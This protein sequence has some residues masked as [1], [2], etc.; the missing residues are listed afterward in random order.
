MN[1]SSLINT[2]QTI[3][4]AA[5]ASLPVL[6]V[7]LGCTMDAVTGKLDCSQAYVAPTTLGYIAIGIG[8]LKLVVLPAIQPG[9]WFRNLFGDKTVVTTQ[10]SPGTVSPADVRPPAQ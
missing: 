1:L 8:F 5:L 4:S 2:V 10:P 3:L 6:L 7:N 9:G